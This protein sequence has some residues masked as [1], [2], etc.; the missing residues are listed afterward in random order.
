MADQ[1]GIQ[2]TFLFDVPTEA[3]STIDRV[4]SQLQELD[5]VVRQ[6][7]G[8]MS[9]GGFGQQLKKSMATASKSVT[10]VGRAVGT[11]ADEA[12]EAKK[13][14]KP[15]KEEFAAIRAEARNVE[16]GEDIFDEK[17]IKQ[18]ERAIR[19]YKRSLDRLGESVRGSSAPERK[20]LAD[21]QKQKQVMDSR[22]EMQRTQR[23]A[24]RASQRI[25]EFA[26][27][28]GAGK[29]I[30]APLT[31]IAKDAIAVFAGFDAKM[32]GVAAVSGAKGE[33]LKALRSLA[34]KMGASTKFSAS[35]AAEAQSFLGM[36]GFKT[37]QILEALPA[38]LD[39]AAAGN[40]DLGQAADIASNAIS[41][42]GLKAEETRRVADVMAKVAA[43]ANT[44]VSQLGEAFAYAAPA[45]H[46]FGMRMEEATALLGVAGNIGIQASA[47]G[48]ALRAGAIELTKADKQNMLLEKLGVTVV[49]AETGVARNIISIVGDIRDSMRT[50]FRGENFLAEMEAIQEKVKTQ[51]GNIEEEL[52][53]LEEKYP[54]QAEGLTTLANVFGKTAVSFWSGQV[55]QYEVLVHDSLQ[56]LAA[57]VDTN[58]LEEVMY[59]SIEGLREA[60]GKDLFGKLATQAGSYEGAVK[61]LQVGLRGL[62]ESG[63]ETTGAAEAMAKIMSNNLEGAFVSLGSA[64][65]GFKI[66]YIEPISPLIAGVVNGITEIVRFLTQLPA[67]I[68]FLIGIAGT[69]AVTLSALAI[70]VGGMGIVLFGFSNAM[71]TAKAATIA[72]NGAAIPLTG[73]FEKAMGAWEGTSPIETALKTSSFAVEDFQEAATLA[74]SEVWSGLKTFAVR[75]KAATF[76]MAQNFLMVSRAFATSPLGISIISIIALNELMRRAVPGVNLFAAAASALGGVLGFVSGIFQGL[77]DVVMEVI[78]DNLK[79]VFAVFSTPLLQAEDSIVSFLSAFRDLSTVGR[80]I[81]RDLGRIILSP[82]TLLKNTISGVLGIGLDF[83]SD[84]LSLIASVIKLFTD[85]MTGRMAGPEDFV[86]NRWNVVGQMAMHVLASWRIAVGIIQGLWNFLVSIAIR[87][88][89]AIVGALNHGAADVTRIAWQ[90]TA[91]AVLE[92]MKQ[93]AI[94]A[95]EFGRQIAITLAGRAVGFAIAAWDALSEKLK[96]VAAIGRNAIAGLEMPDWVASAWTA[97][98]TSISLVVESFRSLKIPDLEGIDFSSLGFSLSGVGLSS[99]AFLDWVA[100]AASEKFALLES[101]AIFGWSQMQ[102]AGSLTADA[103]RSVEATLFSVWQNIANFASR[104][105]EAIVGA[106]NHGAA[107]VTRAAWQNAAI[108]V[109]GYMKQMAI[110]AWDMAMEIVAPI[111]TIVVTEVQKSWAEIARNFGDIGKVVESALPGIGIPTW[112]VNGW[113]A[114]STAIA[115]VGD[116][117]ASLRVPSFGGLDFSRASVSLAGVGLSSNAAK[118]A[119]A[120]TASE[121]FDKM[122]G[123]AISSWEEMDRA[124]ERTAQAWK[125]TRDS[126][127]SVW[128]FVAGFASRIGG[129][130]VNALNHGAA[131]VTEAAWIRATAAIVESIKGIVGTA[132][133]AS[134]AIVGSMAIAVSERLGDAWT[135]ASTKAGDLSAVATSAVAAMEVPQWILDVWHAIADAISSAGQAL[136]AIEMPNF[137]GLDFSAIGSSLLASIAGLRSNLSPITAGIAPTP[138]STLV[139]WGAKD[140]IEE[141]W[142]RPHRAI[143]AIESRKVTYSKNFNPETGAIIIPSNPIGD[144]LWEFREKLSNFPAWLEGQ[145]RQLEEE[146]RI[147]AERREANRLKRE[148]A[149]Q[150]AAEERANSPNFFQKMWIRAVGAIEVKARAVGDRVSNF[151]S[152]AALGLFGQGTIDFWTTQFDLYG[153]AIDNGVAKYR[154]II[155]VAQGVEGATA[156]WQQKLVAIVLAIKEIFTSLNQVRKNF[157][158]A[159]ES[160][161]EKYF[162]HFSVSAMMASVAASM[163]M[164]LLGAKLP[165]LKIPG[166]LDKM[167]SETVRKVGM[168]EFS[169]IF[170]AI[171]SPGIP[172]GL[173]RMLP[174]IVAIATSQ[175]FFDGLNQGVSHFLEN[176][177]IHAKAFANNF[178]NALGP[179]LSQVLDQQ[180]G[181]TREKVDTFLTDLF[182]GGLFTWKEG[183]E[184]WEAEY[185]VMTSG[186][187]EYFQ[188]VGETLND[189]SEGFKPIFHAFAT[190]KP[191]PFL[192]PIAELLVVESFIAGIGDLLQS[193]ALRGIGKFVLVTLPGSILAVVGAISGMVLAAIALI[194][195]L[196]ISALKALGILKDQT[197]E[198]GGVF[199]RAIGVAFTWIEKLMARI[200]YVG[201]HLAK[202]MRWSFDLLGRVFD[203]LGQKMPIVFGQV[204]KYGGIVWNVFQTSIFPVIKNL[205]DEMFS[206]ARYLFD[207]GFL[208]LFKFLQLILGP[209]LWLLYIRTKGL[210][211]VT[212]G[213]NPIDIGITL[214][215]GIINGISHVLTGRPANLIRT[216]IGAI[217]G[218]AFPMDVLQSKMRSA[219]MI[220]ATVQQQKQFMRTG[221]VPKIEGITVQVLN[222]LRLI[223]PLTQIAAR[224]TLTLSMWYS[225]L[226]PITPGMLLAIRHWEEIH[227]KISVISPALGILRFIFVDTID[228]AIAAGKAFYQA[229]QFIGWAVGGATTQIVKG[230]QLVIWGMT[231]AARAATLAILVPIRAL[232]EGLRL[233]M[234]VFRELT[235]TVGSVVLDIK[236][237]LDAIVKDIGEGFWTFFKEGDIRP[238]AKAIFTAIFRIGKISL[239]MAF[240]YFGILRREFIIWAFITGKA[241]F[242]TLVKEGPTIVWRTLKFIVSLTFEAISWV[243][244]QIASAIDRAF[245]AIRNRIVAPTIAAVLHFH[246]TLTDTIQA[247]QGASR[248]AAALQAIIL[249]TLAAVAAVALLFPKYGLLSKTGAYAWAQSLFAQKMS[250]LTLLKIGGPI[251][252]FAFAAYEALTGFKEIDAVLNKIGLSIKDVENLF[253]RLLN[254][255]TAKPDFGLAERIGGFLKG[256]IQIFPIVLGALTVF[257]ALIKKD[258]FFGVKLV[259]TAIGKTI[260]AVSHLVFLFRSI[261]EL[262][263]S[264]SLKPQVL[265]GIHVARSLT[266]TYG[267][268]EEKQTRGAEAAMAK[269]ALKLQKIVRRNQ[270]RLDTQKII[271]QAKQHPELFGDLTRRERV[272]KGGFLGFGASLREE[273]VLSNKGHQLLAKMRQGAY[274]TGSGEFADASLIGHASKIGGTLIGLAP[275]RLR[276]LAK[277][278]SPDLED[279]SNALERMKLQKVSKSEVQKMYVAN[280]VGFGG[281]GRSGETLNK[282]QIV[283]R[284]VQGEKSPLFVREGQKLSRKKF[285]RSQGVDLGDEPYGEHGPYTGIPE[286]TIEKTEPYERLYAYLKNAS[287]IPLQYESTFSAIQDQ[288][289]QGGAISNWKFQTQD[290]ILDMISDPQEKGKIVGAIDRALARIKEANL[291][292]SSPTLIP[293]GDESTGIAMGFLAEEVSKAYKD[294]SIE[295]M[296]RMT[297]AHFENLKKQVEQTIAQDVTQA[298]NRA[299]SS[300]KVDP[301][302]IAI[303]KSSKVKPGILG[304]FD[305][306]FKTLK[307]SLGGALDSVIDTVPFLAQIV[308]G[309]EAR[310]NAQ[311]ADSINARIKALRDEKRIG[312]KD[313]DRIRALQREANLS[314]DRSR[315]SRSYRG[316]AQILEVDPAAIANPSLSLEDMTYVKERRNEMIREFR[317]QQGSIQTAF[318]HEDLTI[319]FDD[320]K[321]SAIDKLIETGYFD[322]K[323]SYVT[324]KVGNKSIS[325]KWLTSLSKASSLRESELIEM[326]SAEAILKSRQRSLKEQILIFTGLKKSEINYGRQLKELTNNLQRL[327]RLHETKQ[328]KA[329]E[330]ERTLLLQREKAFSE[331][332][333]KLGIGEQSFFAGLERIQR[334][335][336][337]DFKRTGNLEKAV[338]KGE[339]QQFNQI[340]QQ[341]SGHGTAKS[342]MAALAE[343]K[344]TASPE[345]LKSIKEIEEQFAAIDVNPQIFQ[346]Q[347]NR[348]RLIETLRQEIS[349]AGLT[350]GPQ[351]NLQAAQQT[352]ARIVTGWGDVSEQK[353]YSRLFYQFAV[354]GKETMAMADA[355]LAE[356]AKNLKLVDNLADEADAAD[357]MREF[358]T[359]SLRSYPKTFADSLVDFQK[360]VQKIFI[361]A[362]LSVKRIFKEMSNVNMLGFHPLRKVSDLIRH[363]FYS[364]IHNLFVGVNRQ[365]ESAIAKIGQL[366]IESKRKTK[367]FFVNLPGVKQVLDVRKS[368][369]QEAGRSLEALIKKVGVGSLG[370]FERN[371][372]N[373]LKDPNVGDKKFKSRQVSEILRSMFLSGDR[374]IAEEIRGSS[375]A[376]VSGS[377]DAVVKAFARTLEISETEA[378]QLFGKD[379]NTKLLTKPLK[380]LGRKYLEAVTVEPIKWL[381][382]AIPKIPGQIMAAPSKIKAGIEEIKAIPDR[383]TSWMTG[384]ADSISSAFRKLSENVNKSVS[385]VQGAT[386]ISWGDRLKNFFIGIG[387]F[388]LFG[389]TA[390]T[391][392]TRLSR[393]QKINKKVETSTRAALVDGKIQKIPR[394]QPRRA[395]QYR[396]IPPTYALK[397]GLDPRSVSPEVLRALQPQPTAIAPGLAPPSPGGAIAPGFKVVAPMETIG[398]AKGS[399]L[400]GGEV[401]KGRYM[402]L[403]EEQQRV[404]ERLKAARES[405]A[406]WKVGVAAKSLAGIQTAWKQEAAGISDRA[407]IEAI[408]AKYKE[409]MA[410]ALEPLDGKMQAIARVSATV[411]RVS[412]AAGRGMGRVAKTLFGMVRD[413]VRGIGEVVNLSKF[414]LLLAK[415]RQKLEGLKHKR[416]GELQLR[417]S[418]RNITPLIEM[419]SAAIAKLEQDIEGTQKTIARLSEQMSARQRA[420]ATFFSQSAAKV[421]SAWRFTTGFVGSLWNTLVGWAGKIGPKIRSFLNH[422]AAT[423]TKIAWDDTTGAVKQDM[424]SI[425]A[426][427]KKSGRA[428]GAAMVN[429]AEQVKSSQSKLLQHSIGFANRVGGAISHVGRAGFA[430]GSAISAVSFGAQQA[431][432]SLGSMGIISEESAAR[433]YKLSEITMI[434]GGIG[435]AIVPIF[436]ALGASLT[437]FGSLAAVVFS[438][439]SLTIVAVVAGLLLL[440]K[441][442]ESLFGINVLGTALDSAIAPFGSQ[443]DWVKE[444]WASL[445]NWIGGIWASKFGEVM[446][447]YTR[448]IVGA[449][450]WA[451]SAIQS[452]LGW[453]IRPATRIAE[454]LVNLLNHNPTERI[455]NAWEHAVERIKD[456]LFGLPVIGALV[457]G[458]LRHKL[459]FL[460]AIPLTI[461]FRGALWGLAKTFVGL[462]A[463]ALPVV[464]WIFAIFSGIRLLNAAIAKLTGYDALGALGAKMAPALTAI[465]ERI[466]RLRYDV[467]ATFGGIARQVENALGWIPAFA[468]NV[469]SVLSKLFSGAV[470]G[471]GVTAIAFGVSQLFRHANL[472]IGLIS[473]LGFIVPLVFNPFVGAVTGI[474][475]AVELANAAIRHFFG[476]DLLQGIHARI[477]S[478]IERAAIAPVEWLRAAWST[479]V[480]AIAAKIVGL[481]DFIEI[482]VGGVLEFLFSPGRW[483]AGIAGAIGGA[484]GFGGGSAGEGEAQNHGAT[485]SGIADVYNFAAA[486]VVRAWF[487][488]FDGIR[489]GMMWLVQPALDVATMLID[490]LNHNPTERIPEAWNGAIANIKESILGLPLIGGAV[491]LAMGESLKPPQWLGE[492]WGSVAGFFDKKEQPEVSIPEPI[493]A[494]TEVVTEP[495]PIDSKPFW[496]NWFGGAQ[497][498][499]A[500]KGGWF[501]DAI[502]GFFGGTKEASSLPVP[503][504]PA[505]SFDW[506]DRLREQQ[507][508]A[509]SPELANFYQRL[510]DSGASDRLSSADLANLSVGNFTEV[511]GVRQQLQAYQ[512]EIERQILNTPEAI[513]DELKG[514]FKGGARK[515]FAKEEA[516]GKIQSMLSIFDREA[517]AETTQALIIAENA[518]KAR[519]RQAKALSE[520]GKLLTGRGSLEKTKAAVLDVFNDARYSDF[521]RKAERFVT[522]AREVSEQAAKDFVDG[523]NDRWRY[524]DRTQGDVGNLFGDDVA[525]LRQTLNILASDF[526]D[527][528]KRAG[529]AISTLNFADLKDAA[530]DFWGNFSYGLGQVAKS[531]RNASFSAIVFGVFSIGGLAP[532]LPIVA[533]VGAGLF[534]LA[535][536][537][538]GIRTI[539]SGLLRTIKG[540]EQVTFG[541]LGG[542]I[543]FV[544]TGLKIVRGIF[545]Y[546]LGDSSHL[547]SA[548]AELGQVGQFVA[549]YYKR[550]FVNIFLGVKNVVLGLFQ[551]IVG[552]FKLIGAAFSFVFSSGEEKGR[553]TAEVLIFLV[554]NAVKISKNLIKGIGL[555]VAATARGAVAVA[556]RAFDLVKKSLFALKESIA[557]GIS[558]EEIRFDPA[559][560]LKNTENL[561]R[562]VRVVATRTFEWIG[563]FVGE[564][565]LQ[566]GRAIRDALL[567]PFK[568]L[569]DFSRGFVGRLL[570]ELPADLRQKA[571][572]AGEG[573]K[574]A[575][576]EKLAEIRAIFSEF[577]DRL[578]GLFKGS[579]D[580]ASDRFG[581]SASE[582]QSRVLS[583]LKVSEWFASLPSALQRAGAT[584]AEALSDWKAKWESWRS[585][586][587]E[588]NLLD[589][590]FA[591]V[592]K[593]GDRFDEVVA[594]LRDRWRSLA[595]FIPG[596]P[597][598]DGV[599]DK[600]AEAKGQF[601]E[602]VDKLESRWKALSSWLGTTPLI[603]DLLDRASR[604]SKSFAGLV[605]EVEARW[606][607]GF[608]TLS[609]IATQKFAEMFGD[610]DGFVSQ[611]KASFKSLFEFAEKTVSGFV[612]TFKAT[613]DRLSDFFKGFGEGGGDRFA[614]AFAQLADAFGAIRAQLAPAVAAVGEFVAGL[615]KGNQQIEIGGDL[616]KQFGAIAGQV[617]GEIA[618]WGAKAVAALEPLAGVM[619]RAIEFVRGFATSLAAEV[620]PALEKVSPALKRVVGWIEDAS[621]VA[622]AAI[623][624]LSGAIDKLL[625]LFGQG[626]GK[627]EQLSR[628]L[629]RATNSGRAFGEVVGVA[630]STAI[631]AIGKGIEIVD[632]L[633]Q[634]IKAIG[635]SLEALQQ[636][637]FGS[638]VAPL[639]KV[640]GAWANT[641]EAIKGKMSKVGEFFSGWGKKAKGDISEASPGPTYWIRKNWAKTGEAIVGTMARASDRLQGL[642]REMRDGMAVGRFDVSTMSPEDS[643]RRL[644]PEMERFEARAIPSLGTRPQAAIAQG[645]KQQG[646]VFESVMQDMRSEARKTGK[647]LTHS[648]E[649]GRRDRLRNF[650]GSARNASLSVA[651][652]VS[653]FAPGVANAAFVANDFVDAAADVKQLLPDIGK[654]FGKLVPILTGGMGAIQ[655]ALMGGLSL[656]KGAAIATYST[657]IAPL[658]PFLPVI[659]GVGAAIALLVQA[660]R[661]DFLGVRTIVVGIFGLFEGMGGFLKEIG[662]RIWNE[663]ALVFSTFDREVRAIFK[664]I[665]YI[666]GLILE[667]FAPLFKAI[668]G[669]EG[670]GGWVG[671]AISGLV[672]LLVFPIQIVTR[673][674]VFAIKLV[675]FFLQGLIQV[676]GAAVYVGGAIQ[677][678]ILWP[679]RMLNAG[680]SNLVGLL[681]K[682]GIPIREG[683]LAPFRFAWFLL[684]K[685]GGFL[686]SIPQKLKAALEGVPA[687]GFFFKKL[688]K[689]LFEGEDATTSPQKYAG[690]GLVTGPGSGTGD[691]IPALLSNGE[692]VVRADAAKGNL[693]LLQSLNEGMGAAVS[694]VMPVPILNAL[695]NIPEFVLE[696]FKKGRE[697]T[698]EAESQKI[699]VNVNLHGDIHLHGKNSK[700]NA[701]EFLEQIEPHLH[702]AIMKFL[703]YRV[704]F[705]R[706]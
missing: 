373:A 304:I 146:K 112:I 471:A 8:G 196:A 432:S 323:A 468:E 328:L 246:K 699:E 614:I 120:A 637:I 675:S 245:A 345:V 439:L 520:V 629:E 549:D 272:R 55:S 35:Q 588:G 324:K 381:F 367:D 298:T 145:K 607:S 147:E 682:I 544:G 105:G 546:L 250:L 251:G 555:A 78:G 87:V 16:F 335:R 585:V 490:A 616:F 9:G 376:E 325:E 653:N 157:M 374:G 583:N 299:F 403:F 595:Q 234:L 537:F 10:G 150:Q 522:K 619:A 352:I 427:A 358:G 424:A 655:V 485:A 84:R 109:I 218:E 661:K 14:L 32:A 384:I 553:K 43:S 36:A 225:L 697:S 312:R 248:P 623:D 442:V 252:F 185:S 656:I 411:L 200:P 609:A 152:E 372:T 693:G 22:V 115:S 141:G 317:R 464:G 88:G 17:K 550:G 240:L 617:L 280:L 670:K 654:A 383:T 706:M 526:L 264:I 632:R 679:F 648:L 286:A 72:L 267:S 375:D 587:A 201:K 57:T 470:L 516:A 573:M 259:F 425:E 1:Y 215:E 398:L 316:I 621:Q 249:E 30:A 187:L 415:Q 705:G 82:F 283:S 410:R 354:K 418:G 20:F 649:P 104:I 297:P 212:K 602:F 100:N 618:Q 674:L 79:A 563:S 429:S 694:S 574:Q 684:S 282:E 448:Q 625:G 337:L 255:L 483:V 74:F 668:G 161:I 392:K 390:S 441:A 58:A 566:W 243:G 341:L 672:A 291:Y 647:D 59:A 287:G 472:L 387:D 56:A 134:S 569:L 440:N 447:P 124:A 7:E 650:G 93:M 111:A 452:S 320:E 356:M 268:E 615:L 166:G 582:W 400:S 61:L 219:N 231:I 68:R 306:V 435:S 67:P 397:S 202:A 449:W 54:Q 407:Q 405:S 346:K 211:G 681:W 330:R 444:K 651:S 365:F 123:A 431:A 601:F 194:G 129:A 686:A 663:F 309:K 232:L 645:W 696:Q 33:D 126:F 199:V 552:G 521:G 329:R 570:E 37:N 130:I 176:S 494:V 528:G 107:D 667:P 226:K 110:A 276:E 466:A 137:G 581:A 635:P 11:I 3:F 357:A 493:K 463:K 188:G 260:N 174:G 96:V 90:K 393:L 229:F 91:I 502:A 404:G 478:A 193:P 561:F 380:S 505:V 332:F 680:V 438:P 560:G 659:V 302:F 423:A 369:E 534:V 660:F 426:Q 62:S 460:T 445:Q 223:S 454:M 592:R 70:A 172:T 167:A 605:A 467:V 626:G 311:R 289:Q 627:A 461:A 457:G 417:R 676:A 533:A 338:P 319:P 242:S 205:T 121:G 262:I 303:V 180:F 557:R 230:I 98:A 532:L 144:K 239:D 292:Q 160:F 197:K 216:L 295:E 377:L 263:F 506:S 347:K 541:T 179:G 437:A 168:G 620:L 170:E 593:L 688:G 639:Q 428:T 402:R 355:E 507:A 85:F 379:E 691:R 142:D 577:G 76:A 113:K 149:K 206:G 378:R 518:K 277:E 52:K 342:F 284:L 15:L 71:A 622:G 599:F 256:A 613:L 315:Q 539:L 307:K 31:A 294:L 50:R 477:G 190:W 604:L 458:I 177:E 434:F 510:I 524:L 538:L 173:M 41:A 274:E 220:L 408:A 482:K 469:K 523:W 508:K 475:T 611:A 186:L 136:K 270:D 631:A 281:Q 488:T 293:A 517:L 18:A 657:L 413:R 49:D 44:S 543:R 430:V 189:V 210:K 269:D 128:Q 382:H 181:L 117:L 394:F 339:R 562:L 116:T 634:T 344:A 27:L 610:W 564:R 217:V 198:A 204:Q 567:L 700:E 28:E 559:A 95:W 336:L 388:F 221:K 131:D 138:S 308:R 288:I 395:E 13:R 689:Y 333:R 529:K 498:A 101:A 132:I 370:E 542:A 92:Y 465:S 530:G 278:A 701:R 568:F 350:T 334:E 481:A 127:L 305:P 40:L 474:V 479:T 636:D 19:Q 69:L 364:P 83:I 658:L 237:N 224:L 451:S 492:A 235:K 495:K 409:Q 455:P 310:L 422:G 183:G 514:W 646:V 504:I 633:I 572:A 39:L 331:H 97:I 359:R 86:K 73:F 484:L 500:E 664:T 446:R 399:V 501:G 624:F 340:I 443:I 314:K 473:K 361:T 487:A 153:Q 396:Q 476:A 290:T 551:G 683:F 21:L 638:L 540:I 589:G 271:Q 313:V 301:E 273:T 462:G 386:R 25:G 244:R 391:L 695:P 486:R 257:G 351:Q 580:T 38:T 548:I 254:N 154:E 139:A 630:I 412:I 42:F 590:A 535:T 385:K 12:K 300:H 285:L 547:K 258:I 66:A 182:Q 531:F 519:D 525:T 579:L 362:D 214:G 363:Q 327:Q 151:I 191:I 2:A 140:V 669:A 48:T 349:D 513:P 591:Q 296:G 103:W 227:Y 665:V 690:G 5:R 155:D 261:K 641:A 164:G 266:G 343:K 222:T 586:L 89:G 133:A 371:F 119:I 489:Q 265:K 600:I 575:F 169:P 419:A 6:I 642:G 459:G 125:D 233:G 420:V 106:L 81:G 279:L 26:A 99:K 666:G 253:L 606:K 491:G 122:R 704:N 158:A 416:E 702:D 685:I 159:E 171:E 366:N 360:S 453:L 175:G 322:P 207:K 321:L 238:F 678:A 241:L 578:V 156:S 677:T 108:A 247:L 692:F 29:A 80:K 195:K 60:E 512:S 499:I 603:P 450:Q 65:E 275:E 421:R 596:L 184:G 45:A 671:K 640:E 24:A 608:E 77:G 698:K 213:I 643:L 503:E 576:S 4:I 401:V 326:F 414:Q 497:A 64:I 571:I 598:F 594:S 51:G 368:H 318:T 496:S 94:A 118:D 511:S 406:A 662:G 480:E 75:T 63:R 208:P 652:A 353:E 162:E 389:K 515:A 673:S 628:D 143:D 456:A 192:P 102:R 135:F 433:F 148:M 165:G 527:F 53:K 228:L 114:V 34:K 236:N 584:I 558:I 556:G 47:A 597:L 703:E 203:Y 565:A 536:N 436:G 209:K 348:N 554:K 612:S 23:T 178:F 687:L 509:G 545:A 46:D 163:P 644:R